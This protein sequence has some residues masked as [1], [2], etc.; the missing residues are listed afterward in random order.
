MVFYKVSWFTVLY[1]FNNFSSRAH[2]DWLE[3]QSWSSFVVNPLCMRR[4]VTVVRSV[5]LLSHI[6]PL[7]C[8]F[9]LKILSRTQQATKVQIFVGVLDLK[10]LRCRDPALLPLKAIHTVHHFPMKSICMCIIV[11]P[12]CK[13]PV[14]RKLHFLSYHWPVSPQWHELMARRV[15]HFSAFIDIINWACIII[16]TP[17]VSTWGYLRMYIAT[18]NNM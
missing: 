7:E 13:R 14:W 9:A 18:S 1:S 10:P 3:G 17:R 5:C 6:S 2:R 16:H 12:R 4:R 8:L 11:L 15:L